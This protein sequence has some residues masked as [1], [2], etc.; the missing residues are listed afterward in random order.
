LVE[1]FHGKEG[2]VGSS[3]TLGL[4]DANAVVIRAHVRG[5]QSGIELAVEETWATWVRDGEIARIEQYG[6]REDALRAAGLS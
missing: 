3:P 1:H 6:A 4:S 2:V 5:A